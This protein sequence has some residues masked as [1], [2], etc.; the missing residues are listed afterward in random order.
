ELEALGDDPYAAPVRRPRNRRCEARIGLAEAR[1]ERRAIG[2]SRALRRCP[3]TELRVTWTLREI[4]VRLLRA[5]PL[6]APFDAD[7]PLELRPEEEQRGAGVRS[8]VAALATVVVRMEDEAAGVHRFQQHDPRGR[9]T[10][11]V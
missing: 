4:V 3:C 1:F 2:D 5:R 8:E 7:L 9:L 11:N 10:G 6:G